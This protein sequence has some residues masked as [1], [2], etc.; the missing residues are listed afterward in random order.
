MLN[1][2]RYPLLLSI[3]FYLSLKLPMYQLL[4]HLGLLNYFPIVCG[5]VGVLHVISVI[6]IKGNRIP[7]TLIL[8]YVGIAIAIAPTIITAILYILVVH[9]SLDIVMSVTLLLGWFYTT[10]KLPMPHPNIISNLFGIKIK[11]KIVMAMNDT[12]GGVGQGGSN[13]SATASGSGTNNASAAAAAV[14]A[15]PLPGSVPNLYPNS[16]PLPPADATYEHRPVH[17]GTVAGFKHPLWR[18]FRTDGLSNKV[19][20]RMIAD[21]LLFLRSN[22]LTPS[23]TYFSEYMEDWL[24]DWSFAHNRTFQFLQVWLMTKPVTETC[25]TLKLY[26]IN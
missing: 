9:Y 12:S 17:I 4:S 7:N 10:F 8:V 18:G 26:V 3:L 2:K 21:H 24:R 14:P 1:F 6:F 15:A 22:N 19:V 20:G 25:L 16:N 11:I 13:T 5:V 23:K